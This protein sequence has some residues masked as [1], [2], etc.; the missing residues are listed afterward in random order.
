MPY[1]GQDAH[2]YSAAPF[3][4]YRC[5]TRRTLLREWPVYGGTSEEHYAIRRS[6]RS[7]A[8]TS[9]NSRSPGPTTPPMGRAACRPSPIVVDG[10]LYGHHAQAQGDRARCR[11][12]QAALDV[13][14]RNRPARSQSRRRRTGRTATT[15]A[16]SPPSAAIVY[17]LDAR[18]GKPIPTFGNE[19]RID[20]REDLGRD[21]AQQSVVL[22][23]PGVIYKDLLIVGGATSEG[24]PAS[25]GDIR[26]YDVRTGKLR[27]TLPHDSASGRVRLRHLAEGRLDVQ[28]RRQQLGG[29]GARRKARHR[30]RPHRSAASDFYGAN[31]LGDNLFA[32]CLLALDADTGE[33]IW[34]FQAVKHD[35]W[36]RDFPVAADAGDGQRDGKQRRRGRADHQ[37]G[38]R[39]SS[40]IARTASRCFRSSTRKYPASDVPTEKSPPKRS[41]CR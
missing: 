12:R 8:P 18:T 7:T 19:G 17:A 10:V 37:A 13:R 2:D 29:H 21:P 38:L 26:A 20:L 9:S 15:G 34:H 6:S 39:V 35:I 33:R 24:L 16:S 28:R 40:S 23:T 11:H 1:H 14:F 31:R 27:W 4:C 3:R 25:P 36:D 30:L 22:T 5:S 32:N 41:R